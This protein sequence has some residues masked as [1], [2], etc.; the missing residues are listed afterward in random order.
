[1]N[2]MKNNRILY[3]TFLVLGFI[4]HLVSCNGDKPKETR[5]T[6]TIVVDTLVFDES[7]KTFTLTIHAD[8]TAGAQVTYSL[9]DGDSLLQEND[10]G[11]FHNITPLVEGYNVQAQVVWDDT[12][13]VTPLTHV[14]NFIAPI[15]PVEPL[16]TED[17]Q[18][19]INSQDKSLLTGENEQLVQDV[20]LVTKDGEKIYMQDVYLKLMSQEWSSVEVVDVK[21]N[22]INQI[23]DITLDSKVVSIKT[24][25]EEDEEWIDEY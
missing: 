18:K 3:A 4:L 5:G 17:L 20:Q 9:F 22:S 8:S 12:T 19:L 7:S 1:M 6:P 13:I 16:S 11:V 10:E 24:P 21:Y 2:Y 15:K 25:T 23:T 14:S